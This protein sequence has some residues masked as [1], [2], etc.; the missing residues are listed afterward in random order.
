MKQVGYLITVFLLTATYASGQVSKQSVTYQADKVIVDYYLSHKSTVYGLTVKDL[1]YAMVAEHLSGDY[2][3]VVKAGKH[4]LVWSLYEDYPMGLPTDE[5][6]ITVDAKRYYSGFQKYMMDTGVFLVMPIASYNFQGQS[7]L[8]G[9]RLGIGEEAFQ[10]YAD[11]LSTFTSKMSA[12]RTV[13]QEEFNSFAGNSSM[14]GLS[15]N[16]GLCLNTYPRGAF[17]GSVGA[18]IGIGYG[19]R[20]YYKM[21]SESVI[22]DPVFSGRFFEPEAGLLFRLGRFQGMVGALA[23]PVFPLT[24]TRVE[25]VAG[26]GFNFGRD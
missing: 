2:R 11:F 23:L 18:Y 24:N 8:Y 17:R 10:I 9:A 22:I 21:Q 13:S 1:N 15:I 6:T 5:A 7:M 25:I 26:L 14:S 3:G 20:Y 19:S 16:V 12:S 4:Q